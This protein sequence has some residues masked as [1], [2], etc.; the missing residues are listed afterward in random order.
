MINQGDRQE[1][2]EPTLEPVPELVIVP[3]P[4]PLPS[5][6]QVGLK[7]AVVTKTGRAVCFVCS[8]ALAKGIIYFG[9]RVE[10]GKSFN[11]LRRCHIECFPGTN[12]LGSRVTDLVVLENLYRS[13]E[14]DRVKVGIDAVRVLLHV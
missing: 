2:P 9:F 4:P 8:N 13:T 12:Y 10:A 5:V 7:E 14:D 1:E 11:Y 3:V 6:V